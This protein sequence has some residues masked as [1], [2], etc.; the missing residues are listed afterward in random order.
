LSRER[1]IV[2]DD[3]P[4]FRDALAHSLRATYPE[5]DVIEAENLGD[6]L[7]FARIDQP[8]VLFL[9]DLVFPGMEG[10]ATVGKLRQ[11]FRA[12]SII[13]VTMLED[14]L[15]A[16]QMLDAGADGYLGKGL[17][18]EAILG[19][20]RAVRAGEYVVSVSSSASSP[21]VEKPEFTPR[22]LDV[23]RLLGD[24]RPTKLIARDLALSHFTVRNHITILMR[25]LKVQRRSQIRERALALGLI[26]SGDTDG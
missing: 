6:A 12:S 15:V 24:N 23:L 7:S 14:R 22:Q 4:M 16:Q 25:S 13:V 11:E 3:H 17:S 10:P 9:L 2:A 18:S 19:G 5:A 20:I 21:I 1:I 26:R 8:P